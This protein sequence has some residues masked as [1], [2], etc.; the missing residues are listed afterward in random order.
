MLRA[1]MEEMRIHSDEDNDQDI[2]VK[3]L[4][5]YTIIVSCQ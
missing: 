3:C 1:L 5:Y 4:S 2:L